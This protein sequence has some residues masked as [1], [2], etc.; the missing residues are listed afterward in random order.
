MM[1]TRPPLACLAIL[2]TAGAT[3]PPATAADVFRLPTYQGLQSA[4]ELDRHATRATGGSRTADALFLLVDLP[5]AGVDP[6]RLQPRA[7]PSRQQDVHRAYV[8]PL[9]NEWYDPGRM[10]VA[11]LG[12][13]MFNEGRMSI[14]ELPN[15]SIDPGRLTVGEIAKQSIDPGPLQVRRIWQPNIDPEALRVE[16]L[17]PVVH[18]P[19]R[20]QPAPIQ[21]PEFQFRSI[22]FAPG[23]DAPPQ[24]HESYHRPP[25]PPAPQR[26]QALGW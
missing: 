17:P 3:C 25:P 9:Q 2:L 13:S 22:I 5:T 8:S 20:L 7:F 18:D 26:R 1:V 15:R 14:S 19:G 6:G 21:K 16:R 24:V 11:P 23:S 10:T 12:R 4:G